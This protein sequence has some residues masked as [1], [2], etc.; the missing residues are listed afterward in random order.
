MGNSSIAACP[1]MPAQQA[2]LLP[3]GI[4]RWSVAPSSVAIS[5]AT[6]SML[7]NVAGVWVSPWPSRAQMA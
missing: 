3:T 2:S 6:R 1:R 7:S 4:V 5:A